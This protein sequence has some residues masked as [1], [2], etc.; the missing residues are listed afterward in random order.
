MKIGGC[1]IGCYA[2]DVSPALNF[3]V[4]RLRKNTQVLKFIKQIYAADC[5]CLFVCLV[6]LTKMVRF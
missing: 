1:C 2:N 4:I 3:D 5:I 6:F